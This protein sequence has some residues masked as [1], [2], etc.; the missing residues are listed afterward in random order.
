VEAF[1]RP[2]GPDNLALRHASGCDA[3]STLAV[4]FQTG[5]TD[6]IHRS[7]TDLDPA[8]KFPLAASVIAATGDYNDVQRFPP[9]QTRRQI[10]VF[11]ASGDSCVDDPTAVLAERWQELG[12]DIALKVDFI[13]L[14]VPPS[15]A[16]GLRAMA[17]AIG[18]RSWFT[19][20]ERQLEGLL[21][22][23]VEYEPVLEATNQ[24]GDTGNAVVDP[25]ND[26]VQAMNQCDAAAARDA[27]AATDRAYSQA[28]PVLEDL[29]TRD[30]REIYI[31]IHAAAATWL[32]RLGDVLAVHD[33]WL[34]VLGA[35]NRPLPVDECNAQRTGE[36][37]AATV[38]SQRAA[39]RAADGA[40][41]AFE[42]AIDELEL[43]L[44]DLPSG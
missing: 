22:Y 16:E 33:Q 23:L 9:D 24:L 12:T 7:L 32:A 31:R 44:P 3:E 8:G 17:A 28:G 25:L 4:P 21:G 15:E 2:R 27:A 11:T 36:Q 5:A 41:V 13:G 19:E 35:T 18:G 14:G 20:D 42:A 39:V 10:I 30:T 37:W 43:Q 40:R 29:A 38:E 1:L 26:F 6:R 34:G